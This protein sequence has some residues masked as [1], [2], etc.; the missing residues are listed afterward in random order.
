MREELVLG[1]KSNKFFGHLIFCTLKQKV[2][3]VDKLSVWT[4]A[5]EFII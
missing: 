2:W 4:S 3:F 5:A 1:E